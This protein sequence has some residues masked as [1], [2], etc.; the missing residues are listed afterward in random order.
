MAERA[1]MRCFSPEALEDVLLMSDGDL[2]RLCKQ[3]AKQK[4]DNSFFIRLD[5]TEN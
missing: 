5:Q 2:T 4:R 3:S 1:L